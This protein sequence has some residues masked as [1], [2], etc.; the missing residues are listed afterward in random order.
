MKENKF[1]FVVSDESLNKYGTRVL[2]DGIDLSEFREN[3]VL[4]WNHKRDDEGIFGTSAK[5]HY[6]IGRW[7]NLR[8]EEGKLIADAV[9][10]LKDTTGAKVAQKIR[11]GFIKAASIGI[12]VHGMSENPDQLLAGQTRPTITDSK[13]LEISIVDIP[14]NGNALKLSYE[15]EI[16]RF[17]VNED[18]D[19]LNKIIPTMENNANEETP[20]KIGDIVTNA[21]QSFFD[22]L[23]ASFNLVP[24]E[25]TEN[26]EAAQ[27]ELFVELNASLQDIKI[28]EPIDNSAVLAELKASNEKL[29]E[30]F[31]AMKTELVTLKG[32]KSSTKPTTESAA[33]GGNTKQTEKLS[34]DQKQ[35]QKAGD[36]FKRKYKNR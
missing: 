20:H 23:K 8:V 14:A 27:T 24:K 6:P 21:V 16:V 35:N 13:L 7:E 3:P 30:Q 36:F 1:S 22:K 28:P 34:A 10:D 9:L 26:P 15:G 25:E 2:T 12:E 5:N 4:F 19:K 29:Q 17:D 33:P 31:N 11:D 18:I 32:Q